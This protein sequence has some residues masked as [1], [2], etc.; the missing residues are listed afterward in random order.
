MSK[1]AAYLHLQPG[2]TLPHIS[3]PLPCRMVVV[4]DSEVSPEWQYNVSGWIARSGCLYMMAWGRECSSW[5][6]SVD[7]ANIEQFTFGEI[8][9]DKF[10][11]TTWHANDPLSEVF[12]YAKNNAFHPTVELKGTVLVHI[13]AENREREL[14]VAYAEA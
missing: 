1:T 5:D 4:V 12:W 7:M 3:A 2:A 11:M 9:E 6:D 13:S 10:I 14:L 8:P